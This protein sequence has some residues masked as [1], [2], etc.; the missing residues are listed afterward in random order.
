[1]LKLFIF[2]FILKEKLIL[3]KRVVDLPCLFRSIKIKGVGEGFKAIV[4]IFYHT[5]R[6]TAP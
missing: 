1:M 4:T 5:G 3:Q 2:I 6:L